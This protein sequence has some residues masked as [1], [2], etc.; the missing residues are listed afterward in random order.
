[1]AEFQRIT[2]SITKTLKE[3]MDQVSGVNWSAVARAAFEQ[4]L[5]K[6]L[7]LDSASA[8]AGIGSYRPGS[9]YFLG[10]SLTYLDGD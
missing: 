3:R 8:P 1:M 2:I 5:N 10:P 7:S 4:E 9:P 6:R